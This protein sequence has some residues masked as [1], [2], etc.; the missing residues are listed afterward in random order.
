VSGHDR[1]GNV[2][3]C[4][5]AGEHEGKMKQLIFIEYRWIIPVSPA[6]PIFIGMKIGHIYYIWGGSKSN[7]PL[8]LLVS[9]PN[10]TK[11]KKNYILFYS[12]LNEDTNP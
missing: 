10:E 9:G 3:V 12:H 2:S 1:K 7:H 11:K 8:Y 6:A 5:K 4:G